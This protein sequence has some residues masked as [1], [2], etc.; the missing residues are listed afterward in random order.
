MMG[1]RGQTN[2]AG[3]PA[4]PGWNSIRLWGN[5]SIGLNWYYYPASHY[6]ALK[7]KKPGFAA[8]SVSNHDSEDLAWTAQGS[9]GR[10]AYASALALPFPVPP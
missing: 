3:A 10:D 9:D 5:H 4:F 6:S 8:T 7:I 1:D 2:R